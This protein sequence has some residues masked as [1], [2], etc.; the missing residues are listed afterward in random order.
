M[1]RDRRI[2][3]ERGIPEY[4]SVADFPDPSIPHGPV[5]CAANGYI[6]GIVNGAWAIRSTGDGWRDITGYINVDEAGVNAFNLNAFR[7]GNVRMYSGTTNDKIDMVFHIPHDYEMGTDLYIHHHWSHNG[8]AIS[9]NLNATYSH[10]Y[11]KGY[12]RGVF[13]VEKQIAS[14]LPTP[15]VTAFPRWGHTITEHQLS[16]AGGSA[17]QQDN[18]DIEVDALLLINFTLDT[19]PTITGASMTPGEPFILTIDLHYKSTDVG[20]IN[21]NYPFS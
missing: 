5:F 17:T 6:Y 11:A 8:T 2:I 9:G 21:R 1:P 14:L 20:T 12:G 18:A 16:K 15:N 4:L 3:E 7:G 10:T 13:G 19:I